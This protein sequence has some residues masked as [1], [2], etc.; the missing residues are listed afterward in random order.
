V[1]VDDEANGGVSFER[2]LAGLQLIAR[3]PASRAT[4]RERTGPRA[5]K[6]LL[7][8][9]EALAKSEEGLKLFELSSILGSPNSSLLNMLRPLVAEGFLAHNR[10]R[11]RLGPSIFRLAGTIRSVWNFSTLVRPY[12][13]ELSQ[14]AHESVHLGVLD[15]VGKVVTYLDAIDSL[16]QVRYS[17]PVG[18]ARPLYATAA[19]LVLLAFADVT[20]QEEYLCTTTLEPHTHLTISTLKDLRREIVRIRLARL[21]V[22]LGEMFPEAAALAA[23]IFGADGTVVAAVAIG[24]PT[25]RLQP[26]LEELR[27]L[28]TDVASRASG[29]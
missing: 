25:E 23:P 5:L 16:H 29:L 24:A 19:G 7:G 26:R 18:T 8:V 9:F 3:G 13:K 22:S 6:R 1:P 2:P 11:Y 12:L 28:I 21:S 20:W 10:G 15:R 4:I 14:R 17:M 27:A